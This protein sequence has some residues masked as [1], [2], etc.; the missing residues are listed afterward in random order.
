MEGRGK[1][2]GLTQNER[3]AAFSNIALQTAFLNQFGPAISCPHSDT[4]LLLSS[5]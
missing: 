5:S 1:Q 3:V 2:K 4:A